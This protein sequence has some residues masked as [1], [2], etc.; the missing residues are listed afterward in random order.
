MTTEQ[1]YDQAQALRDLGV[2][3]NDFVAI[4]REPIVR[5]REMLTELKARAKKNFKRLVSEL[6]PD[7]TN[8]DEE[9]TRRFKIVSSVMTE[10]EKIQVQERPPAP[11]VVFLWHHPITMTNGT[12]THTVGSFHIH[13]RRM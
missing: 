7:K 12:N 10:L 11:P 4:Q 13:I 1:Q 8:G 2:S 5:A 3:Q 9:K 6:H